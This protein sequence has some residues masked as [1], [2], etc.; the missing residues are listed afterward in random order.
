MNGQMSQIERDGAA[1]DRLYAEASAAHAPAIARLARAVEADA[2][3]ARDLEQDI[4][5]ALW[6]SLA[7]FDGRCALGTWTYR[8]A[9]NAAATH[10]ARGMRGARLVAIE[11]AEPLTA[12]EDPEAAIDS[13]RTLARLRKL[14][15]A[16]KPTD[17]S[18]I[19]LYLEGVEAAQ[20]A[21]VTG[22]SAGNVA[23]KVHRIKALLAKHFA[24]GAPA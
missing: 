18:L 6:R 19:L 20:I 10:S 15:A 8:V 12:T 2:D 3:R 4:H 17:R 5:L 7:L 24:T 13:A 11:D 23:V 14:I 22:L 21:E 1:Q 9:H 16:L